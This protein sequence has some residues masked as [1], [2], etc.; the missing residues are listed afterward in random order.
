MLVHSQLNWREDATPYF[1]VLL[2]GEVPDWSNRVLNRHKL[3]KR[4]SVLQN[5]ACIF[6]T[7]LNQKHA[8]FGCVCCWAKI[9]TAAIDTT[10][11]NENRCCK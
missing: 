1:G 4:N 8:L 5:V 2:L 3:G 9:L 6:T 10:W 7:K 11:E